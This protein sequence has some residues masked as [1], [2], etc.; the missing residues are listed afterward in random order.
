MVLPLCCHPYKTKSKSSNFVTCEALLPLIRAYQKKK[1]KKLPLIR[2]Q[3][4]R[5]TE[6]HKVHYKIAA[7]YTTDHTTF[8]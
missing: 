3:A 1:K 6:S 7:H 8:L 4:Q 5:V 2:Y